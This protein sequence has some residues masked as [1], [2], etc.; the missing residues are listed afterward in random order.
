MGRLACGILGVA[1]EVAEHPRSHEHHGRLLMDEKLSG[2]VV[3]KGVGP[4]VEGFEVDEFPESLSGLDEAGVLEGSARGASGRVREG[5]RPADSRRKID[6]VERPRPLVLVAQCDGRDAGLAQLRTGRFQLLEG[7]GDADAALLEEIAVVPHDHRGYVH[8]HGIDFPPDGPELERRGKDPPGHVVGRDGRREVGH[9]A[10]IDEGL[11]HPAAPGEE[12]VGS[13]PGRHGLGEF[14]LVVV[15]FRGLALDGGVGVGVFEASDGVLDDL[16]G[17]VGDIDMPKRD[18]FSG[19]RGCGGAVS[20][21]V[22]DEQEARER[23]E[24]RGPQEEFHLRLLIARPWHRPMRCF[25]GA[26]VLRP[27]SPRAGSVS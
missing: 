14:L 9:L 20:A 1:P 7:L 13:G 6:E 23:E 10:L 21:S 25:R 15:V 11:E 8:R 27:P 12:D 5:L 26:R 3:G 16:A 17:G 2:V 18:L 22:R 19:R 24:R 4:V